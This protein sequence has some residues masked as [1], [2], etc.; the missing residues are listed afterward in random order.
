MADAYRESPRIGAVY[1]RFEEYEYE[2]VIVKLCCVSI[3]R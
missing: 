1:G 2:D 3:Q